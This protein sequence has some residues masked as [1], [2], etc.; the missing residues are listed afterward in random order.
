[1]NAARIG[2]SPSEIG[3][4]TLYSSRITGIKIIII[5]IIIITGIIVTTIIT[6]YPSLW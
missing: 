3:L 6:V 4:E 1:M 2:S 5:V